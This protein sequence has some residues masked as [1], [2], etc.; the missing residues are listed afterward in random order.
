ML[1]E[2]LKAAQ[3]DRGIDY[4][5][6]PSDPPPADYE[7]VEE[8]HVFGVPDKEDPDPYGVLALEKE[9]LLIKEAA[10]HTP[11]STEEFE[12]R[13]SLTSPIYDSFRKSFES[14][15]SRSASWRGSQMSMS[16]T[17][18]AR[19]RR[20]VTSDMS[21]QTD[22]EP[23]PTS[24]LLS[25][26]QNKASSPQ[27]RSL[28]NGAIVQTKE[29]LRE[30][31]LS[32]LQEPAIVEKTTNGESSV[33]PDKED[34]KESLVARNN[35]NG[36]ATDEQDDVAVIQEVK[37][38]PQIAQKARM[39]A[40][41]KRIPPKLPPRNPQ[42]ARSSNNVL[43]NG[44][45][46]QTSHSRSGSHAS[47]DGSVQ[48]SSERRTS[49]HSSKSS[50][51]LAEC[52]VEDRAVA[53]NPGDGT[54]AI[55]MD[56]ALQETAMATSNAPSNIR[57]M[58]TVQ[59]VEIVDDESVS[60]GSFS[61][62]EGSPAIIAT[63]A[64]ASSLKM[65]DPVPTDEPSVAGASPSDLDGHHRPGTISTSEHILPPPI[66]PEPTLSEKQPGTHSSRT[67][68]PLRPLSFQPVKRSASPLP[69]PPFHDTNEQGEDDTLP[70]AFATDGIP[71][72]PPTL[73]P[74][75][76]SRPEDNSPLRGRI[77][78]AG[79]R[80]GLQTDVDDDD[81]DERSRSPTKKGNEVEE[82]DFS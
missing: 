11:V 24:P 71:V 12:F 45:S 29:E 33:E 15:M 42:R 44:A 21:T 23:P 32:K 56:E 25:P 80:G 66:L 76:T 18:T 41:P 68:S 69:S 78:I 9:G 53:P 54:A 28:T 55:K 5:L 31:S 47:V 43:L 73:S 63:A 7:V 35:V 75:P 61:G 82:E 4:N 60:E 3:G 67:S 79:I 2:T 8:G 22:F 34:D 58:K 77:S 59:P 27:K 74:Q 65:M 50:I 72:K 52:A 40:V 1:I 26:S 17:Q 36:N 39:I 70:G 20:Y 38:A 37:Q 57:Q 19:E 30:E 48:S 64:T 6:V 49:I 10:T 62:S 51:S 46:T 16:T 13:P 81:D 14:G